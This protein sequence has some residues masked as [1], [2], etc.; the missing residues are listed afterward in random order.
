MSQL[1][2]GLGRGEKPAAPVTLIAVGKIN[3]DKKKTIF[4]NSYYRRSLT[5][6]CVFD[7]ELSKY[8]F[9]YF[10]LPYKS[11]D[12]FPAFCNPDKFNCVLC[13]RRFIKE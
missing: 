9:T 13:C 1:S 7:S 8:Q 4:A 12:L 3:N 5:L 11:H 6:I 2:C 10:V